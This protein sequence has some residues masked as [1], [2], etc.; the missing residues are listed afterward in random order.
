MSGKIGYSPTQLALD[1]N[2]V[3]DNLDWEQVKRL[4]SDTGSPSAGGE[5]ALPAAGLRY[6]GLPLTGAVKIKTDL[7]NYGK[8]NWGPI[9][10]GFLFQGDTLKI[11][12]TEANLCG[13][14][15]PGTILLSPAKPVSRSNPRPPM[16]TWTPPLFVFGA[17]RVSWTVL[18]D[19]TGT[20]TS[21]HSTGGLL[22]SLRG[23]LEVTARRGRIYR[24][25]LLSKIFAMLNVTEIYRVNS[26]TSSRKDAPT[27]PFMPRQ[28]CRTAS[29]KSRNRKWDGLSVRMVGKGDVD[30]EAATIN[31]T[32]L[33]SPLKTV[34]TII[35]H[36]PL[37]GGILGGSLVSIPVGS[38][39]R[40]FGPGCHTPRAFGGRFG[41]G[42]IHEKDFPDS[43]ETASTSPLNRFFCAGPP[44]AVP[45]STWNTSADYGLTNIV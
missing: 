10:A 4:Q 2:I 42:G 28:P 27:K 33:V 18:F 45:V 40:N 26:R 39:G 30:L 38:P 44:A 3:A 22:N 23:E 7:F 12:V 37:I 19:L 11:D 1:L 15:T 16:R 21:N 20:L 25:E 36:V 34:D 17:A 24:F 5:G 35:S 43:V 8:L 14:Q 32:V 9:S 29:S 6:N 13:I 31:A 41:T